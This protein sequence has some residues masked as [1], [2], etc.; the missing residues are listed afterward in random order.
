MRHGADAFVTAVEQMAG[1][2][3]SGCKARL[4]QGDLRAFIAIAQDRTSLEAVLPEMTMP[5]CLYAGES[6]PVFAEVK[7]ASALIPNA[8]FFSLPELTHLQAFVRADLVL[9]HITAFLRGPAAA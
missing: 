6:D 9:P 1:P 7:L 8:S 4:R 2:P 3:P 5:C